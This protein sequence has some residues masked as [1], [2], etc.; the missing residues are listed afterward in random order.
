MSEAA[1]DPL[2]RRAGRQELLAFHR[3][4]HGR[5]PADEAEIGALLARRWTLR[6]LR[7]ELLRNRDFHKE[8][9]RR[10]EW[11]PLGPE[12]LAIETDAAPEATAAMLARVGAYW[13]R[14][15][16]EKPHWSVLTQARFLP[17]AID[18]HKAEFDATGEFEA[19]DLVAVLARHGV[20][21]SAIGHAVD[22]GC[23]V[24]RTTLAMARHFARVTGCD[25]SAPHMA[26]A[27]EEAASRGLANLDWHLATIRAP[28]P[29]GRWDFWHSR[30]VLQHNPPPV[31]IHLLRLA[32]AGLSPGGI[33]VFQLP[34][35]RTGYGFSVAAHLAL[36]E[37][38]A[39]EMHVVP[40]A[41]IFAL[42]AEAGLE[43]LEVRE[44]RG[45]GDPGQWLSNI[46][47]MR[48]PR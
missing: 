13:E 26:V 19:G 21:A 7:Q 3:L 1:A 43:V 25:I 24:G 10:M 23:G 11:L 18:R 41:R 47:V 36:A 2:A 37:E 46:F 30:I 9:R 14:V 32:F 12:P 20:A 16:Q 48:R 15:G 42:A 22:F 17:D 6:R 4:V 34:T 35:H 27:R 44:D 40:Q 31:M 45:V 5:E 29:P 8:V 28:M 38:P 33:A 39:M